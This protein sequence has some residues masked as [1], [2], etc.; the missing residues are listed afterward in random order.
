MCCST[1]K[2]GGAKDD[3]DLGIY[4]YRDFDLG[5]GLIH[6]RESWEIF[7]FF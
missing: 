6:M 4:D 5:R 1:I 7:F 2:S 3:F